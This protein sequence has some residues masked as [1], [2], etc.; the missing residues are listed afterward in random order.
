[1][2]SITQKIEP[3]CQK[4][5]HCP[6]RRNSI[7]I[8]QSNFTMLTISVNNF[9]LPIYIVFLYYHMHDKWKAATLAF[10][11]QSLFD[12][13]LLY[14]KKLLLISLFRH[15][16]PISEMHFSN[17]LSLCY[18]LIKDLNPLEKPFKLLLLLSIPSWIS[19]H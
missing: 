15:Y 11:W 17:S 6:T 9:S 12:H 2:Y 14:S 10:I 8:S 7:N 13:F 1:M 5:T 16:F 18:L 19:T 3:K 4:I